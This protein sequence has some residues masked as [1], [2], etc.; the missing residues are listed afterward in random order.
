[1]TEPPENGV[2]MVVFLTEVDFIKKQPYQYPTS[3]SQNDLYF[4]H[5]LDNHDHNESF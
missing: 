1:M 4:L 5:I 2:R 3:D